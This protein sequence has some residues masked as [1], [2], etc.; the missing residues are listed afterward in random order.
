MAA[1]AGLFSADA[2]F[3]NVAGWWWRGRDEIEAM[4]ARLHETIFAVSSMDMWLAGSRQIT[5]DIYVVHVR[6]RMVGHGAGGARAE[7][8]SREGIWTWVVRS[9]ERLEIIASHNSDTL[10]VPVNHPLAGK[11][12][13]VP[14]PGG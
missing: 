11:I 9:G 7:S 3:V 13:T 12:R 5:E 6:W 8:E 10:A 1:F 2:D 14:A 4:H